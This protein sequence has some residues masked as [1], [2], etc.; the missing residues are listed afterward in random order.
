MHKAEADESS[1]SKIIPIN[2]REVWGDGVL[3]KY[4]GLN[5]EQR[6][7]RKMKTRGPIIWFTRQVK[8]FKMEDTPLNPKENLAKEEA[9]AKTQGRDLA[10]QTR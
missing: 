1:L 3:Y 4:I 5:R 8:I 6:N 7:E 9:Q 10:L 2:W